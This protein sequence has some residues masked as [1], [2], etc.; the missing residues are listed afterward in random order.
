M[1]SHRVLSGLAQSGTVGFILLL[2]CTAAGGARSEG[3]GGSD[4]TAHYLDFIPNVGQFDRHV[5][6]RADGG[7]GV[8]WLGTDGI[9][10]QLVRPKQDHRGDV[11]EGGPGAFQ[12]DPDSVAMHVVRVS[13][14]GGD[15]SRPS[16][17]PAV[18]AHYNYFL[19]ADPARW[20]TGVPAYEGVVFSGVYPGIDLR[21]RSAGAELEYDFLVSPG[22]D[23][24]RVKI[25]YMG[26]DRL[27][28]DADGRLRLTTPL[29]V[30]I[31][32]PPLAT[33]NTGGRLSPC[34]CRF[35]RHVDGSIGFTLGADYNPSLPVV[36]DPVLVFGTFLGGGL[37]DYGRAV[38]FSS[39]SSVYICGYSNSVDF[40]TLNPYDS[41]LNDGV[42]A[43]NDVFVSKFSANGGTLVYST[44]IGG[45]GNDRG[46]G[47]RAASGGAAFVCGT[48]SSTDFPTAGPIQAANAGGSDAF[49]LKLAPAGD[50]LVYSTYLGGSSNES[51]TGLALDGWGRVYVT[52]NTGSADFP[53]AAAYD[54]DLNGGQ[55]AYVTCINAQGNALVYST[56]LGGSSGDYGVGI[57][58]GPDFNAG[59]TGYTSS[60]DFPCVSAFDST[61]NGGSAFGDVFVTRLTANGSALVYSTYLGGSGDDFGLGIDVHSSDGTYVTGY[62]YSTGFPTVKPIIGTMGG[63]YDAFVSKLSSAGNVLVYSTFI[64]GNHEDIATAI[65]VDGP[66]NAYVVGN[67]SSTNFP[68]KAPLQ[69]TFKGN[70]DAFATAISNNGDS[71]LYSTYLGGT[72]FEF[73]YGI[74]VLGNG[75]G[76]I[77][78]YSDSPDFPLQNPYQDSL[79][80]GYDVFV[81]KVALEGYE[82]VDTDG[83]GYGDPGHP[84]NDCPDDNCPTVYNPDQVDT[85]GD[86]FGDACDNCPSLSNP[87]Q[88]DAD[89]DGIGDSCDVCTDTDA[90]GYGNP[91]YPKNTCQVDNCPTHHNPGQQDADLDGVGD[92]CDACTDTDGDGY[93]NPGFPANT[94]T[95][96]NCP[97]VANPSQTDSDLDG[98]GNACDNCPTVPNPG[99]QDYD[100]DGKGDACDS[101]TDYDGDG[102][103]NPGFPA[104]TCPVDNCPFA[105]NPGQEDSDSN[106]IGDACDH[107]C[108]HPPT[109]GNVDD[110]PSDQINI[111]DLVYLV[112]YMFS[113]GPP[114]PCPEEANID[115]DP[116][117]TIDIADLVYL[118]TFMFGAGDPPGSCP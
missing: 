33:Q 4:V 36:I 46:F 73:A 71:L 80:G 32:Q 8:I 58:V 22:A 98:R 91:G 16:T 3:L 104:N 74:A 57:A 111:S 11:L 21:L 25:Q 23:V 9:T 87:A 48:T 100:S 109:T 86:T 115:G 19:G 92:S 78:G 13:C 114:P 43:T 15:W 77:T 79:I 34:E 110:D 29:G 54:D 94:C 67:T 82:C 2:L 64:G 60:G 88:E 35:V 61:F 70:V 107:G 84:E 24:S 95:L 38:S 75:N 90:D 39:D 113:Q 50:S 99:Q 49:V 41:I 116:L 1:T 108:C 101:C 52:G 14:V 103:G 12:D 18:D 40:P 106:G 7:Q 53:T 37:S 26:V 97:T 62:T 69:T 66:G 30:I 27:D 56:Y 118:V 20:F 117:G 81:C 105:Y 42:A 55:D 31:E 102:Y 72:Y 63:N 76:A 96:D 5:L 28:I 65:A 10:L 51:G 17:L 83:D 93:G 68:L 47:I 44:Y 112:S 59:V 85:D 45:A 6:F 89:L